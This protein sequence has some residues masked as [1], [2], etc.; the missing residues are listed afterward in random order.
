MTALGTCVQIGMVDLK[1]LMTAFG[2]E[3][4]VC[5]RGRHAVGK[6]EGTYQAAA[7]MRDDFY[8]NP[9]NVSK[10]G[11]KYEQGL[12]VVERRLSQLTEGDLTGMPDLGAERKST[13]F[14]PCDWLIDACERPV[15]LFL[16]ERNRALEGVKQAVF[17]LMDS[18][19]FYGYKLHS[20]TRVVVAENIGDL[21]NVQQ[22]DPAEVSRAATVELCPTVDEWCDYAA[23]RCH[24]LVV[25]FIRSNKEHL[26]FNPEDATK[27][28]R[29]FEPNKKYP[30]RRS[31]FK[32]DYQLVSSGLIEHCNDPLFYAMCASM[33]GIEAAL[34][35]TDF[36]KNYDRQISVKDILTNWQMSK[37]RLGASATSAKYM[38][39]SKKLGAWFAQNTLTPEQAKQVGE[40]MHDC[41]AEPRMV[42]W[43]YLQGARK[44]LFAV[45]PHVEELMVRTATGEDTSPEANKPTASKTPTATV[46]KR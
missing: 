19:A 42:T 18:R 15:V 40:Y 29:A 35:F 39:L 24:P 3:I 33:V 4:S 1:R 7:E 46:N 37:K 38:E 2:P 22:C 30:D 26:E 16:D 28:K 17:Q 34:K 31:W 12:P 10:Y 43:Q 14:K 32:L 21:Y 44:N 36:A 41:P 25:D 45:H 5:I 6:S 23:P 20:G 27:T 13:S 8:K 11:W 9:D